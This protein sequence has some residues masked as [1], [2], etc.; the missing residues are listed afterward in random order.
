MS[1]K[2]IGVVGV[3]GGWSS[4]RLA[5]AL[6]ERTG[7]RLLVDMA[8]VSLDLAQ[9]AVMYQGLDL[10][11]L[12]GLVVKKLGPVYTPELLDRLEVLRFLE[13][14]G[15]PV[16]SPTRGI[17]D[18]LDRLSCTVTLRL[19][20]IP[21]PA[22]TIT[23]D[24]EQAARAL[25][26]MGRGVLKPL[27]TTKARG[28]RVVAHGPQAI[29]EIRAFRDQGNPVIYL[30]QM[31]DL[32]GRDLGVVFLGGRYLATYARSARDG[33]WS[34]STRSGGK[35]RPHEP[36]AE[37]VELA[38]RAQA[39]FKLDFTCVDVAETGAGPLVF[40]VSAFGGFRGLLDSAGLDAAG[41]Y[42]DHV[43]KRL[44]G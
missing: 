22:T 23:E 15:V 29:E 5:D 17:R 38:Q 13:G 7:F 44:G 9:G 25:K 3:P 35:Y 4:E 37:I 43:L 36:T 14:R 1:V 33:S 24:P 28:M 27:F 19:G 20:G 30:Q 40:E 11:A 39:L 16:F 41:L 32:P 10:G 21:M 26:E 8:R 18:L 31:A 2:R 12:D 6:A 42:A 34:T